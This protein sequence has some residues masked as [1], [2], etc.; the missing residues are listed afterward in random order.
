[1]LCLFGFCGFVECFSL[2]VEKF[3]ELIDFGFKSYGVL[4]FVLIECLFSIEFYEMWFWW[5]DFGWDFM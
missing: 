3:L 1:M 5:F 4:R 2:N